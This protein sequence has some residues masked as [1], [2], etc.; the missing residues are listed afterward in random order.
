MGVK[1]EGNEMKSKRASPTGLNL[2]EPIRRIISASLT[3]CTFL[4]VNEVV[5]EILTPQ[6]TE[7]RPLP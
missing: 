7:R 3:S 2:P 5:R 4:S 6:K 1:N